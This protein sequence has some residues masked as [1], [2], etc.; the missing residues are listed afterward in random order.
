MITIRCTCVQLAVFD[1]RV[2][3]VNHLLVM[4]EVGR[5]NHWVEF[6][7]VEAKFI[8][9]AV[10]H[11]VYIHTFTSWANSMWNRLTI[12]ESSRESHASP[13]SYKWKKRLDSMETIHILGTDDTQVSND[14]AGSQ[15]KPTSFHTFKSLIIRY[16]N[17]IIVGANL[18]SQKFIS[19]CIF[20]SLVV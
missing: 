20:F 2:T 3:R 6:Y 16:S 19:T 18:Y 14:T 4:F 13:Y 10:S 1:A 5:W 11:H 17:N 8:D 15:N 12:G 9:W 7:H